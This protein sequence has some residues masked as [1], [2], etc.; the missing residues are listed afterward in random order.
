M[1]PQTDTKP[2]PLT[3]TFAEN[4][5]I[6]TVLTE[7]CAILDNPAADALSKIQAEN[8]INMIFNSMALPEQ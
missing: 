7:A 3:S 4:L 5:A 1:T 6:L 8:T 2:L